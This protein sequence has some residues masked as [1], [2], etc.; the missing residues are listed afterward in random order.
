MFC[1]KCGKEVA[2]TAKFCIKCGNQLTY[3]NQ[4]QKPQ[5]Q[6]YN[7]EYNFNKYQSHPHTYNNTSYNQQ[8]SKKK[9]ANLGIIIFISVIGCLFLLLILF[10]TVSSQE[11]KISNDDTN[12]TSI[13]EN[14]EIIV[15]EHQETENLN[16]TTKPNEYTFVE[17]TSY[18]MTYK[19]PIEFR[20]EVQ[21]NN[22]IY[23]FDDSSGLILIK[24]PD[25]PEINALLDLFSNSSVDI[26]VE[27]EGYSPLNNTGIQ[28]DGVDAQIQYSTLEDK[29][30]RYTSATAVFYKNEN[31]Y[32]INMTVKDYNYDKYYP[33]FENMLKS[34][35]LD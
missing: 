13:L 26:T 24:S 3:K 32:I 2:N 25:D 8:V 11:R 21:N 18:G 7:N 12:T 29:N 16:I 35:K 15:E 28:I 4:S 23:H 30:V 14:T 1:N 34:I 20:L 22:V 6:P 19:I 5:H 27:I 31:Y 9:I 33:V 17:N 10:L